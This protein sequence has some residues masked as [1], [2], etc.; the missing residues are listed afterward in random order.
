MSP[1]NSLVSKNFAVATTF[2]KIVTDGLVLHLD[3][4][5]QNSYVSGT[6]WKDLSGN[7]NTGTLTNGAT[8]NNSNGG[9]ISFDGTDDYVSISNNNILNPSL[10]MTLSVWINISSFVSFMNIFGK[11]TTTNGSGGYDF[12][13]ESNNQLNLVKYFVV[14]Q[15]VTLS[16]TL[17]TN[18][19]Y[20]IVAV[21]S[22]AKVDYFVNG[23]NVGNYTNSSSYQ[24]NTAEF[25]IARTRDATY[26]PANIANILFYK[27]ILTAAEVKQNFDALKSRF[28]I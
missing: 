18:T 23:S 25:R 15:R 13:I 6:T 14:D 26:T 24:T 28:G 20:N 10:S 12:R 4:G 11:G 22:S 3:A 17:S 16:Q 19:W 8:F 1:L 2:P 27:K 7:G 5:Q 21:Q 9:N